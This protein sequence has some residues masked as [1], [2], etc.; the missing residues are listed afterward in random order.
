MRVNQRVSSTIDVPIIESYHIFIFFDYFFSKWKFKYHNLYS[1]IT[2]GSVCQPT[3]YII[4]VRY[5]K[6]ILRW[7]C[8]APSSKKQRIVLTKKYMFKHTW[9]DKR[10]RIAIKKKTNIKITSSP[11]SGSNKKKIIK[12]YLFSCT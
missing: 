12:K 6:S 11:W 5:C 8:S 2:N 7:F 1:Q 10:A 4:A 9:R 3:F